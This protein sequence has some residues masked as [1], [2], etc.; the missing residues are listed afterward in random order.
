MV[1]FKSI[2]VYLRGNYANK[3]RLELIYNHSKLKLFDKV[4]TL[5]RYED[6]TFVGSYINCFEV[7]K[8]YSIYAQTD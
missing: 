2:Y 3:L 7:F 6:I 8:N 5:H 1:A 4:L